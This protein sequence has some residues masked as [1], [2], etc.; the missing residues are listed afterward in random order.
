MIDANTY[1]LNQHMDRR[2]A[3]YRR[4]EKIDEMAQQLLEDK[5]GDYY[6]WSRLAV[7]EAF[8]E[9]GTKEL[10]R[11]VACRHDDKQLATAIR[12]VVIGYWLDLAKDYAEKH[13]GD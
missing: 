5:A 4:A 9:I 6:P 3:A 2:D 10:E 13:I 11:I 7:A 12:E 1:F 8:M